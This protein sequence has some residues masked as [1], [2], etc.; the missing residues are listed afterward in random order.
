[1]WGEALT[2]LGTL[3]ILSTPTQDLVFAQCSPRSRI[4]EVQGVWSTHPDARGPLFE[5]VRGRLQ[6]I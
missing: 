6:I 3:P 5:G 4:G 1:M 2:A